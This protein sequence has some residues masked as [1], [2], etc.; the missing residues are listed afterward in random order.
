[1]CGVLLVSAGALAQEAAPSTFPGQQGPA[2]QPAQP[3]PAPAQ[4]AQPQWQQPAA[5]PR[6]PQPREPRLSADEH[7]CET[8][9]DDEEGLDQGEECFRDDD[10]HWRW[11]LVFLTGP[12]RTDD[13]DDSL[14][15]R[16]YGPSDVYFGGE[17]SLLRT[18]GSFFAI[19]G[20]TSVRDLRWLHHERPAAAVFGWD[21]LLAAELRFALGAKEIFFA[22]LD[23]GVGIGLAFSRVN[24]GRATDVGWRL[25]GDVA[26][27]LRLVGPAAAIVRLGYDHF[28]VTIGDSL[29]AQLGGFRVTLGVEVRE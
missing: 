16:G 13:W 5:A 12:T 29:D 26:L 7:T 23:A 10:V 8:L 19:G 22:G 27:G 15:A 21:L 28:P 14:A 20:R 4:P 17:T 6:T 1:M 9:F 3:A 25:Q 18:L 11:Q 2:V 24:D